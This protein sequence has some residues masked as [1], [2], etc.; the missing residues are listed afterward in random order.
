MRHESKPE[1][2][3]NSLSNSVQRV[4]FCDSP[5]PPSASSSSSLLP[6]HKQSSPV[7]VRCSPSSPSRRWKR[8]NSGGGS[9]GGVKK[10]LLIRGDASY[11]LS[12]ST[13]LR[14]LPSSPSAMSKTSPRPSFGGAATQR[15]PIESMVKLPVHLLR[16][17]RPSRRDSCASSL[18]PWLE[19]LVQN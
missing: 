11:S 1:S 13:S 14:H 5:P 6:R 8:R 2:I 7:A 19:F 16:D 4:D 10:S 9:G 17:R 18:G 12:S 3:A 15:L